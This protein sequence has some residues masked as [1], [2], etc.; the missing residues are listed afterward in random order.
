MRN[1]SAT[2]NCDNG[3]LCSS[4]RKSQDGCEPIDALFSEPLRKVG[5]PSTCKLLKT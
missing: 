2:Y 5:K 4:L 3:T 1:T